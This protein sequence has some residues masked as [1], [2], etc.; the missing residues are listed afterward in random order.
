MK[1]K[2]CGKKVFRDI[3]DAQGKIGDFR[4]CINCNTINIFGYRKYKENRKG[5]FEYDFEN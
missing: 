3:V 2:Y 4:L 1:C 5:A